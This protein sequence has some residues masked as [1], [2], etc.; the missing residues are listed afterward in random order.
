MKDTSTSIPETLPT[1]LLLLS[2]LLLLRGPPPKALAGYAPGEDLPPARP[3]E[4]VLWE[5]K[6]LPERPNWLCRG[7]PPLRLLLLS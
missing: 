5:N 3:N 2:V 7:W 6:E 4:G 1:L